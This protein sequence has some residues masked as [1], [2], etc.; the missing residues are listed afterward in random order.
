MKKN[1][2]AFVLMIALSSI[3]FS[4][5]PQAINYQAVAGDLAGGIL[6]E[7]NVGVRIS[8]LQ[9]NIGGSAVYIET[10]DIITNQSGMINLA[11][12]TGTIVSGDF[13]SINWGSS[14][15]YI[16]T[17]IDADGGTN[18]VLMAVSLIQATP[19]ALH[20]IALTLT[21]ANGVKYTVVVDTLGNLSTTPVIP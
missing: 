11:I 12:G 10:H 20:A 14:S 3:V 2:L 7:Q 4:Q 5:S 8:I 19:Y 18:Y 9:G 6:I 17:E 16:K 15:Y 21:D 13:S 1:I